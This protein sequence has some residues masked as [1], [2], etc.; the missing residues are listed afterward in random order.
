MHNIVHLCYLCECHYY[1]IHLSMLFHKNI[2]KIAKMKLHQIK[3]QYYQFWTC[4]KYCYY[5]TENALQESRFNSTYMDK[6]HVDTIHIWTLL[7]VNFDRHKR[8]IQQTTNL[9]IFKAFSLH[10]MTPMTRWVPNYKIH[11]PAKKSTVI[12]HQSHNNC[13]F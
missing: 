3:R 8:I 4:A 10:Y 5:A 9:L 6:R 2:T 12:K 11:I 7:T 1:H 13:H